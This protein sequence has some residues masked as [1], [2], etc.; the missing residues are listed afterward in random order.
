MLKVKLPLTLPSSEDEFISMMETVDEAL[1]AGGVQISARSMEA[2][3]I[4]S[5]SLGL[6]LSL[7]QPKGIPRPGVF[8]GDD[9]TLRITAWIDARYGQRQAMDFGPG[10]VAIPLRGDLWSVRLPRVFGTAVFFASRT[11]RSTT[12][13]YYLPRRESPKLNVLEQVLELPQGLRS[14]LSD[15]ELAEFLRRFMEGFTAMSAVETVGDRPMV[16]EARGDLS[17]AFEFLVSRPQQLGQARYSAMQAAEKLIK[18]FIDARGEN[19]KRIHSISKLNNAAVRLGLSPID[20]TWIA[21]IECTA[22]PRYGQ[23]KSTPDQAYRAYWLSLI[24]CGQI[25]KCIGVPQNS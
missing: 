21:A 11:E 6:G 10:L 3:R 20:P 1:R 2:C 4:I 24:T 19:F 18:S 23:E 12:P 8:V 7:F 13:E 14:A 22:D 9:L 25:A 5:W 16:F 17:A 15:G